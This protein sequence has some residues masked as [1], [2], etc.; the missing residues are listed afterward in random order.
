MRTS[1]PDPPE[2]GGSIAQ[3][4]NDDLEVSMREKSVALT[5]FRNAELL[6]IEPIP[7]DMVIVLHG[8]MFL[9]IGKKRADQ[10]K[11]SIYEQNFYESPTIAEI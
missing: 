10:E 9:N 7:D 4:E 6:G 5:G 8:T 11:V 1:T 2:T 3:N